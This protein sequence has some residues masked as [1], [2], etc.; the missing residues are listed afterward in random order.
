LMDQPLVVILPW[1]SWARCIR[2]SGEA[3][4]RVKVGFPSPRGIGHCQA[5]ALEQSPHRRW[6]CRSVRP[7]PG[8]LRVETVRVA[9]LPVACRLL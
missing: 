3:M 6:R 7:R 1:L 5:M 8:K 9:Q 4:T 2:T